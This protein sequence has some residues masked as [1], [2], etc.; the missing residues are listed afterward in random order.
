[1][2]KSKCGLFQVS[3]MVQSQILP[4]ATNS[5]INPISERHFIVLVVHY[6]DG[7]SRSSSCVNKLFA[8]LLAKWIVASWKVA[9]ERKVKLLLVSRIVFPVYFRFNRDRVMVSQVGYHSPLSHSHST[10]IWRQHNLRNPSLDM[11]QFMYK[12]SNPQNLDEKY[13]VVDG[14]IIC[15]GPYI[16]GP[17]RVMVTL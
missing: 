16:I 17:C 11:M 6:E 1:M 10:I 4:L 8:F 2:D 12:H 15:L 7:I 5:A 3:V 14:Y 13:L 9:S